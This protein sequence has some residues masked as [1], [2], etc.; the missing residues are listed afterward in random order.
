MSGLF[1][2]HA[3]KHRRGRGIVLPQTFGEIGV[4]ALVFFFQRNGQ[5]QNF[6][7]G[8]FVEL[9]HDA[10]AYLPRGFRHTICDCE[11]FGE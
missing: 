8:E 3:F 11:F 10:I 2:A 1:L 9:L 7:F 5:S 6:A 4:D